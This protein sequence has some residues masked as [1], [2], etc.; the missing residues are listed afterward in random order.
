M[1]I[2]FAE[3]NFAMPSKSSIFRFTRNFVGD[4]AVSRQHVYLS[5]AAVGH[6]PPGYRVLPAARPFYAISH[7]R[8]P[9]FFSMICRPNAPNIATIR[10]CIAPGESIMR[11]ELF[12]Y[13]Q[14]KMRVSERPAQG[15]V[16][17]QEISIRGR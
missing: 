5:G 2:F 3:Q 17:L 7:V 1:S 4:P 6:K 16:G 8:T 10:E 9:R 13:W 12:N 15:I 11:D 14:V